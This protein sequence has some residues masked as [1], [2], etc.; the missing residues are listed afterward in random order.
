MLPSADVFAAAVGIMGITADDH[1]V[2]YDRHG[3]FSAPRL[4]WTFKMFG[5]AKVS[6]LN[7]GLPAWIAAGHG[8]DDLPAN[9]KAAVY[10][11]SE[12]LTK[13]IDKQGVLAALGSNAQIIDARPPGRFH[14]TTPEPRAGLRGGRYG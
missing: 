1:V 7:G 9:A 10:K 5:H 11:P 4:W 6:V 13:V 8:V 3:V 14:G 2:V 12:P